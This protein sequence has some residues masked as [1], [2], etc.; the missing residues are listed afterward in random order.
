MKKSRKTWIIT[1]DKENTPR[2]KT[3]LAWSFEVSIFM[4]GP[5][6][7]RTNWKGTTK[8]DL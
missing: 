8:K 2:K 7:P 1:E 6:R 3:V 4:R 5:V